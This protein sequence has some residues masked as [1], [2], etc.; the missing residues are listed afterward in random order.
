MEIKKI[1]L[2]HYDDCYWML[3]DDERE[4]ATLDPD[5]QLATLED[6]DDWGCVGGFFTDCIVEVA[7]G[8]YKWTSFSYINDLGMYEDYGEYETS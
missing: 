3:T 7:E 4:A 6:L 1:F 2:V 5:Y 8:L